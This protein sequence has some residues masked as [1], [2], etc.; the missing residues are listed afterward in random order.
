RARAEVM[1][2]RPSAL[3]GRLLLVGLLLATAVLAVTAARRGRALAT[4]AAGGVPMGLLLVYQTRVY[5]TPDYTLFGTKGLAR[6]S[7][8]PAGAVDEL[9]AYRYQSLSLEFYSGRP[10]RRVASPGELDRIVADGRTVYV[11]ADERAWPPREGT[12]DRGWGIVERAR[13][14]GR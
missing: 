1:T 6:R 10:V 2:L 11:V 5:V 13:I 9:V 3:S 12:T 7:A 4:F 14:G 8:P